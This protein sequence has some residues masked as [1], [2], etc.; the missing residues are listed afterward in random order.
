MFDAMGAFDE[1]DEDVNNP[2]ARPGTVGSQKSRKSMFGSSGPG[3]SEPIPGA[4]FDMFDELDSREDD[5]GVL[6]GP[7]FIGDRAGSPVDQNPASAVHLH[8]VSTAVEQPVWRTRPA[9]IPAMPVRKIDEALLKKYFP[10]AAAAGDNAPATAIKLVPTDGDGDDGSPQGKKFFLDF[11]LESDDDRS[12]ATGSYASPDEHEPHIAIEFY[13]EKAAQIAAV[14][15]EIRRE[16][17]EKARKALDAAALDNDLHWYD[18]L[19]KVL[20]VKTMH[21]EL[22]I[23]VA[24][25]IA[26]CLVIVYT[27]LLRADPGLLKRFPRW[28]I[29]YAIGIDALV[30]LLFAGSVLAYRLMLSNELDDA[31]AELHPYRGELRAVLD[32]EK[33]KAKAAAEQEEEE[34]E[35]GDASLVDVATTGAEAEGRH[36]GDAFSNHSSKKAGKLSFNFFDSEDGDDELQSQSGGQVAEKDFFESPPVELGARSAFLAAVFDDLDRGLTSLPAHKK[37]EAMDFFD[38]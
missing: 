34:E 28:W 12:S 33:A 11:M 21:R 3:L 38:F 22:A 5:F 30:Q 23:G 1:L 24:I 25:A 32:A 19:V 14:E 2:S 20:R 26:L 4:A 37:V 6:D 10:D 9:N 36:S 35:A 29:A 16:E 8:R 17:E 13:D 15:R 7:V 31:F 18:G 27:V